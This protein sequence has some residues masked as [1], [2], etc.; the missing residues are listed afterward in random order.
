ML[1]AGRMLLAGPG[2]MPVLGLVPPVTWDL[3][4]AQGV[5]GQPVPAG[6]RRA[7]ASAPLGLAPG[8]GRDRL[9]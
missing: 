9:G 1:G 6:L 2:R 8:A 7:V 5:A 4:R 3:A